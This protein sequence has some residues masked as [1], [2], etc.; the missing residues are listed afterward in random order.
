MKK[1]LIATIVS[2]LTALFVI[3][4]GNSA[5]LSTKEVSGTESSF[6]SSA[7]SEAE[8][9]S[10]ADVTETK[11]EIA[12]SNEITTT[13]SEK[14][15]EESETI[16]DSNSVDAA[17]WP[18][19][20]ELGLSEDEMLRIY[21]DFEYVLQQAPDS[22]GTEEYN[23]YVDSITI[24]IG[25]SY[26]LTPEQAS[27]VYNYIKDNY[28]KTEL[29]EHYFYLPEMTIYLPLKEE[30]WKCTAGADGSYY[31]SNEDLLGPE[32][33]FL[34]ME[35]PEGGTIAAANYNFLLETQ[36]SS[37]EREIIKQL[38]DASLSVTAFEE[39]DYVKSQIG[40]DHLCWTTTARLDGDDK[41]F[42]DGAV[43]RIGSHGY[44]LCV[45]CSGETF[46]DVAPVFHELLKDV[47]GENEIPENAE[48][49]E[50]S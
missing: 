43:W 35:M 37:L 47:R 11:E 19:V 34:L 9:T 2:A 17:E 12:E 23:E 15:E 18:E 13:S 25:A 4:C 49:T 5:S 22:P 3:G 10:D 31:L 38:N 26:G 30:G 39:D 40:L 29:A 50:I 41:I 46:D 45:I 32:I 7:A 6:D 21:Q 8:E 48:P 27:L 14:S 44:F 33:K 28:Y 36:M 1:A 24:T 42:I 16:S 20:A